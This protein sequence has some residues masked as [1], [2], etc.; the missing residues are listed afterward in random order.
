M[1][2]RGMSE[3]E[4]REMGLDF[5]PAETVDDYDF[6]TYD[7]GEGYWLE[8]YVD[9]GRVVDMARCADF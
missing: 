1:F 6:Y 4:L 5:V 3:E 9:G 7:L 8:L 2:Y